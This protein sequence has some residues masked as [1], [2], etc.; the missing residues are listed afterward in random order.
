M[1]R[2]KLSTKQCFNK[3]WEAK[4]IKLSFNVFQFQEWALNLAEASYVTRSMSKVIIVG[5]D[6][7]CTW[8]MSSL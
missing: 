8:F 5:K 4:I 7:W 3:F 2:A 6:S 1:L